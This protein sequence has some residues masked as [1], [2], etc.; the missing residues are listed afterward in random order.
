[1]ASNPIKGK[2]VIDINS[3][4]TE[5]N[6]LTDILKEAKDEVVELAKESKK[7]LNVQGGINKQIDAIKNETKQ[8][9]ELSKQFKELQKVER[10]LQKTEQ[11]LQ[12]TSQQTLKTQQQQ[13]KQLQ[14]LQKTEVS[15]LKTKKESQKAEQ[16]KIK[17][18]RE[19]I[20][21]LETKERRER[22]LLKEEERL[23]KQAKKLDEI[24]KKQN[25]EYTKQSKKL[26]DLRLK[27]KNLIL[28]EGK[29]A[30]GANALKKEINSL[31]KKLK[32][33]DA[34]VGQN[35]RKVGGYTQALK[36]A[37]G[38]LIGPLGLAAAVAAA[39]V[40]IRGI[41]KLNAE[42]SDSLTDVQ[43]TT[44]LTTK[45]VDNLAAGLKKLDTRSNLQALLGIAEAAGRMN[46]AKDDLLAFTEVVDKA[47]VALGDE[48]SGTAEEIATDLA[49]ISD[50]FDVTAQFGAAE[51]INKLG[52]AINEL[53]AGT[54]AQSEFILQFTKDLV[55]AREVTNIT[56]TEVLG[57]AA[58]LDEL[59]Q[60]V[61][62]SGTAISGVLVKMASETK[63][64]A[65]EAGL[66]LEEF[67]DLINTDINEALIQFSKGIIANNKD[68]TDLASAFK[69][70]GL[71]GKKSV[72]VIGALSKN[73]E[74]LEF[75]QELAN[76]AFEEG[77][78]LTDEFNLKN[79]NLAASLEKLTN[80]IA[81]LVT[82]PNSDLGQFFKSIVDTAIEM[83]RAIEGIDTA[84]ALFGESIIQVATLGF[85]EFNLSV[86]EATDLFELFDTES[87]KSVKSVIGSFK[88][89]DEASLKSAGIRNFYIQKLEQEGESTKQ[90]TEL[91][92]VL[93]DTRVEELKII[94]KETAAV[95]DN[96]EEIDANTRSKMG[97]KTA[98]ELL[99]TAISDLN[100]VLLDQA[101][102]GELNNKTFREYIRLTQESARAQKLLSDAVT[103]AT[104]TID[105][106]SISVDDIEKS[107]EKF[108]EVSNDVIETIKTLEAAP[109]EEEGVFEKLFGD[110]QGLQKDIAIATEFATQGL[111]VVSQ[112]FA[113]SEERKLQALQERLDGGIIS[114]EEF[115]EKQAEIRL[116]SAKQQRAVEIFQATISGIRA[117]IEALPNVIL[118]AAVGVFSAAQIALLVSK[119][120]P[121][122]E[123]GG[124][125][126]PE[127]GLIGGKSH[128]SGGTKF[129]DEHGRAQ[130][131]AQKGEVL[132][133]IKKEAVPFY[134][135][136]NNQ[137]ED[138]IPVQ[139]S[140]YKLVNAVKR[141]G[142]VNIKN[143]HM[144]AEL[145][146]MA[147]A[148]HMKNNDYYASRYR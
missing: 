120:L 16:E 29:A 14:E 10:E 130:F 51:G 98:T 59:G 60:S 76:K 38:A 78:S 18:E 55:G 31:D 26:N 33:L 84:L 65:N 66:N 118:A 119:P 105:L 109:E 62:V 137:S 95:K 54:K 72:S 110:L 115:A 30:K 134:D 44:G 133:I 64:F 73:I 112:V 23:T 123:K 90:A 136:V 39:A 3:V 13:E 117:V 58:T 74:K 97:N 121:T 40:A 52:S 148:K 124:V 9:I 12:K 75:N 56:I 47:F 102:S 50:V 142:N 22:S 143:A 85:A 125:Y 2:D 116:K 19:A 126:D 45:E 131:E 145:T 4:R 61:S 1:L 103:D 89:L 69:R 27:Y 93:F 48:L 127:T 24:T 86:E 35:T 70:L 113:Q 88:Q 77:T 129:Y 101:L 147:T 53:G 140:D 92:K 41:I 106:E 6:K 122:F 71:D 146:G 8:V 11:E 15:L 21:T 63:K 111:N 83:V 81:N 49:K 100:K 25:N 96:S 144:I 7:A 108:T 37:A 32:N 99:N 46:I 138:D 107:I 5:F 67:T 34:S 135:W 68:T 141:N 128:A 91:I 57:L 114:E 28:V 94:E 104:E 43:K 82:D 36:S 79:N 80:V 17:T 87:G 42:I 132:S 20:R 139:Q